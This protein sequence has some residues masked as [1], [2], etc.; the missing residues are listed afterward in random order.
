MKVFRLYII[1][2]LMITASVYAQV[3]DATEQN[4]FGKGVKFYQ[5]LLDFSSGKKNTTR[6]DAFV[7]IPYS[8]IQF[9]KSDTG[10]VGNFSVT[11]S[12]FN[13]SKE[14]LITEKT[15]NE[16]LEAK[17]FSQTTSKDHYSLNLKSFYLAPATYF[18]RTAVDDKESNSEFTK[19]VT[20]KV[21]DLS[22]PVA[23]S[24]IMLLAKR[25][26]KEGINKIIPN[27][28]G[29]VALQKDGLPVFYE[30]YS[31]FPEKLNIEYVIKD[32]KKNEIFTSTQI[33]SVDS[34]RTQ[35]FYTI[36]DSTFSLG[37]YYLDIS[38]KDSANNILASGERPFFSRWVGVP[39]TITDLDKA[40][41]QLIYIASSKE[42]DFIKDATTVEEKL[43]RY[44]AFWKKLDPTP[45]TEDN[46]I[47]NEY[48]RRIEYANEH[49]SHYVE[50]WKT[51][52]GM[53]FIL[54]GSPDNVD[55]HP[56]DLDSKP[57]EVWEY[58]NLNQSFTFVDETG[59]G[60]YRLITPLTGDLYRFRR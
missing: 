23:M 58:Y 9:V 33:K 2:I 12:I 10:F 20:V 46:E 49:F 36:K 44:L 22:N 21:R 54:L 42:I 31:N 26:E 39:S 7:M 14:K 56:F 13:D 28:S 11:I 40:V 37:L 24:D 47:F 15:W 3:E 29:N 6:L 16:T 60:D 45:E 25:I 8:S 27:I 59:F 57:Y 55:R 51:D 32:K 4:S 34:G 50:G 17:D 52:R 5:N 38:I 43:K 30:I 35:I 19:E 41:E 18:I 1:S 48:Y 53:V